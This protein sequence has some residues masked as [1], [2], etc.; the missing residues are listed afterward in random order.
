MVERV[1][2]EG[3]WQEI[4]LEQWQADVERWH[5]QQAASAVFWASWG[6]RLQGFIGGVLI[7]AAV[8]WLL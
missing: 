8:W 5:D 6:F 3:K 2:F 7:C 4:S 1:N